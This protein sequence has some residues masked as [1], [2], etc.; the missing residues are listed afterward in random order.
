[1]DIWIPTSIYKAFPWLCIL[2]GICCIWIP[3]SFMKAIVIGYLWIYGGIIIGKRT[4][5]KDFSET[6]NEYLNTP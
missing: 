2:I 5:Y 4:V 6:I 3:G 1:M